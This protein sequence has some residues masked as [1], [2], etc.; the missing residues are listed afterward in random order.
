MI[1]KNGPTN[2]IL[3]TTATSL[4]GENE[5]RVLSLP[6]NDTRAQTAAVMLQLAKGPR[7][8]VDFEPW[9]QLQRWLAAGAERRVEIPYAE[10]LALHMP[11]VSVRLRRDFRA[12]LKLI[13]A[14]AILHQQNRDRDEL[15]RIVAEEADYFAVRELIADLLSDGVGAT[16]SRST[17]ETVEC[18]RSLAETTVDGVPVNAAA[19]ALKLDKSAAS[20]RLSTAR[21]RGYLV[22]LEDRRGRPTR[23][24]IGEPLPDELEL[25][26]RQ[27]QHPCCNTHD[28]ETLGREGCCTVAVTAEGVVGAD[29]GFYAAARP[30]RCGSS[31]IQ[32]TPALI[33]VCPRCGA[34]APDPVGRPQVAPVRSVIAP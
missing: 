18:V 2:L 33:P 12:L 29:P 28:G 21:E 15:G 4:H 19:A 16:V 25:L 31:M 26:P 30:C 7:G 27:M 11:P 14:H 22:N 17:R 3:T 8:T 23:Y 5:T 24:A 1:E 13:E 32:V 9:H 10:Y 34:D 6:M 20:R